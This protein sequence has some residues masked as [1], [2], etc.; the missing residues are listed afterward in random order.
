MQLIISA[1]VILLIVMWGII[2]PQS[3]GSIFDELLGFIT[4]TFGWLY[5]WIVLGLVVVAVCTA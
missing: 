1:G 4:V 5:L 3:L 2:A